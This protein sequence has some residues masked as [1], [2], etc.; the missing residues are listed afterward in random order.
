MMPWPISPGRTVWALSAVSALAFSAHSG[1][2]VRD[3]QAQ[4]HL[5]EE[6]EA[7]AAQEAAA[8]E[9]EHLRSKASQRVQDDYAAQAKKSRANAAAARDELG[10]LRNTIRDLSEVSEPACGIDAAAALR[11]SLDACSVALQGVAEEL[12]AERARLRG[13]QDWNNAM[14]Q[15][16][17]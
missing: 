16:R 8:R 4:E 9:V 6:A 11:L 5:K 14:S 12:D 3:W 2:K 17:P 15:E 1:W 10:R 7:R 13:L